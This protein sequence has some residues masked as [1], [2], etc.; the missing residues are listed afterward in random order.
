[1]TYLGSAHN[2]R[3]YLFVCFVFAHLAPVLYQAELWGAEHIP[4]PAAQPMA[5]RKQERQDQLT[6]PVS[7]SRAHP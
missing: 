2:F 3:F 7:L 1:M 5:A 4:Q 6:I